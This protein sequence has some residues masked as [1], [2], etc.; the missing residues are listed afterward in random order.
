MTQRATPLYSL[1]LVSATG[2]HL[3]PLR[4]QQVLQEAWFL[5]LTWRRGRCGRATI[6][7]Y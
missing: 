3:S 6:Y 7:N 4:P 2:D 5:E 1:L